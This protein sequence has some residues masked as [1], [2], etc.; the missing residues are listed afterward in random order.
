MRADASSKKLTCHVNEF[1]KKVY[2]RKNKRKF[3]HGRKPLL[4][5]K[6]FTLNN[7]SYVNRFQIKQ[8][9]FSPS[10]NPSTLATDSLPFNSDAIICHRKIRKATISFAAA[11]DTRINPASRP[12]ACTN[13]QT[14]GSKP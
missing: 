8:F 7:Q 4:Q 10:K 2:L 9:P 3:I 5:C 1:N 14:R 13:I 12:V 11:T 6:A